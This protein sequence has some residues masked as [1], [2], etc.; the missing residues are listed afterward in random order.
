[1]L[2]PFALEPEA[3]NVSDGATAQILAQHHV[4]LQTWIDLGLLI[5]PAQ[6]ADG[7][8]SVIESMPQSFRTRWKKAL[9]HARTI[10][11]PDG[12]RGLQQVENIKDLDALKDCAELALVDE[13]TAMVSLEIPEEEPGRHF[14]DLNLE[15]CKFDCVAL[16]HKISDV[17][18]LSETGIRRGD[19]IV[20]VWNKRFRALAR[21]SRFVTVVDRY[22]LTDGAGL[23]GLERFLKELDGAGRNTCLTVF[24]S[25]ESCNDEDAASNALVQ[26]RPKL[27]RGG[28]RE[29][30]LYLV[31]DREFRRVHDRYVRFERS[32]CELG[33]GLS[34]LASRDNKVF[35]DCSFNFKAVLPEHRD[36]EHLLKQVCTKGSPY[37]L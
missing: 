13:T 37:L 17:E 24:A 10:C 34:V 15:V 27:S 22:A 14:S 35:R 25:I 28:I 36:R 8:L 20:D 30:Q 7:L 26:I 23:A 9:K 1:M 16:S 32:V 4:F 33:E 6:D 18:A 19:K 5:R 3:V 11:G 21:S 31:P 12:W 2:V 29:I